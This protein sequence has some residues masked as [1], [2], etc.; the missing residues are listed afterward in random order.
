MLNSKLGRLLIV[1]DE[2]ETLTPLCDLL[3]E[4]GYEVAGYTSPK[5]AL[6]E[7]KEKDF[8][9]LLTDLVMPEM[10][11]IELIK[12]AMSIDTHLVC[13]IITGKGTIQ[14]AVEAMKTG[15]FDYLLKPIEW[16]MLR[17]V[18]SRAIEVRRLRKAEERY[19]SIVEDQTELVCRFLPDGKLTF[20]NEPC[21]LLLNKKREE[22]IGHSFL[23]FVLE[24]DREIVRHHIAALNSEHPVGSIENRVINPK[25]KICWYR[26]TTRTI[27][28]KHGNFIESQAVGSDI[29]ERK[30]MEEELRESE[31]RYRT[32][33]EQ[34]ADCIYLAD[35][36]TR[37]IL[38]AN[39][40]FQR[41]LGYSLDEIPR[42]S[43]YDFVVH[44]KEDIDDKINQLLKGHS[45]F[46]GERRYLRKDGT[47]VD[48][49]VS[50]S[51][52]SYKGRR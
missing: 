34:S 2:I 51:L 23:P 49:E 33:I 41:L 27:F 19:R 4:W 14:T 17:P 12:A 42:L 47:L 1:D 5:D 16:K 35:V 32:V 30:Q 21:C 44:E 37:R 40:S 20:V 50:L 6:K 15:A 28:D 39:E 9:L 8:D 26:W 43:V 11:G 36:E 29:T 46:L 48:V 3:S 31:E 13:I 38:Q 52:T 10:D 24:E 22:L 7:L 45:Y 25:G 18:L